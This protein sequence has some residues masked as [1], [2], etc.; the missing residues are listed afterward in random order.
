[1]DIGAILIDE[2]MNYIITPLGCHLVN[3]PLDV[4]LGKM[5]IYACL[6]NCVDPILTIAA[7]L[8]GKSPLLY[9]IDRRDEA[10]NIHAKFCLK[11]HQS[12]SVPIQSSTVELSSSPYYPFSDHL[13]ITRIYDQWKFI[14]LS[15]GK[16]EAFEFC[17]QNYLSY[18]TLEDIHDMRE[19]FRHYLI[20]S[21]LIDSLHLTIN[22]YSEDIVRC[23]LCAGLFPR[24]VRVCMVEKFR[25]EKGKK[26]TKLSQKILDEKN[27]EISIHQSSIL[28][29]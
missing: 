1:M 22:E 2:S 25:P 19:Q 4:R 9:P 28:S 27:N 26:N 15:Q 16:T 5:L 13:A 20:K 7:T 8:A 23:A 29:K 24:I 12:F 17:R 11:N 6:F 21:N 3:L 18:N 14:L 10:S